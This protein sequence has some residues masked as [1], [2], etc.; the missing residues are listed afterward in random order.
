MSDYIIINKSSSCVMYHRFKPVLYHQSTSWPIFDS[1][2]QTF[3]EGPNSKYFRLCGP[4]MVS[5][6][7]SFF[8]K[9]FKNVDHVLRSQTRQ[10]QAW[11][12]FGPWLQFADPWNKQ[13]WDACPRQ[14]LVCA[15]SVLWVNS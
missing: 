10:K 4:Y 14:Q 11:P 7:Y 5:V 13:G 6:T 9:P 12:A 8:K 1:V 3:C 2:N 15:A